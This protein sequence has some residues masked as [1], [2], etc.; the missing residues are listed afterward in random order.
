[1]GIVIDRILKFGVAVAGQTIPSFMVQAKDFNEFR[2]ELSTLVRTK[3]ELDDL[4]H[5]QYALLCN[6]VPFDTSEDKRAAWY[7][8]FERL[9]VRYHDTLKSLGE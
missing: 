3:K 6:S 1:M 2:T 5:E 8:Q 4:A 7:A 9:K